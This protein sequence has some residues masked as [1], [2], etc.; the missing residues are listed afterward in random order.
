[1]AFRHTV[2]DQRWGPAAQRKA[3]DARAAL[4]MVFYKAVRLDTYDAPE[5]APTKMCVFRM[6]G[7]TC[8]ETAGSRS[9]C[10]Y[11]S[12][13]RLMMMALET[14]TSDPWL[15]HENVPEPVRLY[16][17]FSCRHRHMQ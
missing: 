9:A 7:I 10:A 4:R 3:P 13:P 16:S 1:M 15:G 8:E 11:S 14:G 5:Y 2:V 17:A 12:S 6:M